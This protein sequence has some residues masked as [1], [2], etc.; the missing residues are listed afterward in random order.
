MMDAYSWGQAEA[1]HDQQMIDDATEPYGEKVVGETWNGK[2]VYEGDEIIETWDGTT[3][4]DDKD[5]MHAFIVD[6]LK[7][8]NEGD[9]RQLISDAFDGKCKEA[10]DDGR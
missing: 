6:W 10:E 2:D 1:R 4:F 8:A 7:D 9:L 5:D 3:V